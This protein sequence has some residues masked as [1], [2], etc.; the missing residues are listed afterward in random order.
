[1]NDLCFQSACEIARAVREKEVSAL[2]V[3]ETHLE[4][5]EA[6]H[7]ALNAVV[8]LA[9]DEARAADARQA[10]G[11]PIGALHGV[12]VTIKDSIETAGILTTGGT[13]GLSNHVPE[14]DAPVVTRLREAG[15]IVLGKTNTPE[16]TLGGESDNLIF[17]R[18]SNPYRLDRT[19]GGSSGGA[20]AIIAAGGAALDLGSDVGGSIREPAHYCG[21]AG[22]KPTSGRVPGTGHIPASY[23][24]LDTFAQIGPMARRVEDIE[25]ALGI[26]SGIDWA[27]P[28]VVP[29]PLGASASVAIQRLR[30]A[31][32]TDN[33]L[34]APSEE[35]A[36]AVT[37]AAG[38]LAAA[39]VE[40]LSAVPEA[41]SDAVAL[42]PRIRAAE[43]GAPVRYALDLAG[44]KNPSSR[45]SYA[46]DF[47]VPPPGNV[48]SDLMIELDL[49]RARML[50]FLRDFDAIVCP[51]SPWCAPEHG[52]EPEERYVA[53]SHAMIYNLTGWPGVVVRAGMSDEGLPIGVQVVAR[54][55]REDV[56]FALARCIESALGGYR[57]PP[58]TG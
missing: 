20:A 46:L 35:I 31:T 17:G 19:P 25:L 23:G 28:S 43:G 50:A 26:V 39:G 22:I 14:R 36:G 55:W 33:G 42:L 29:M 56:A 37:E 34:I 3:V 11:D 45:L 16:L 4:R 1:M 21:I 9:A 58:E 8:T 30:V 5:I 38:T 10:S 41:I 13:T 48:L 44:T 24:A 6:T 40:V 57:P 49:V 2:E 47:P 52:F 12:P 15:A 18:T 32:Y 27:D 7:S 54:P 53:W 51:A